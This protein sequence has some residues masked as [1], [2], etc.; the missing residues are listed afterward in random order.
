[1]SDSNKD[2]GDKGGRQATATRVTAMVMAT[3]WVMAMATRLAGNEEGKGKGSKG[4][5]N[6]NK[7]GGQ[8]RGQGWQGNG[9]GN[10]GGWRADGDGNKEGNGNEDKEDR[11]RR[12]EW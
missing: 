8:G 11:Q 3:M 5:D 1:M 4:N 6:S 10:K 9:V 12:G 2:D 7:G